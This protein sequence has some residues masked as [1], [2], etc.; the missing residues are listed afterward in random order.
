MGNRW[1]HVENNSFPSLSITTSHYSCKC[2]VA[3]SRLF[4]HACVCVHACPWSI[5]AEAGGGKCVSWHFHSVMCVLTNVIAFATLTVQYNKYYHQFAPNLLLQFCLSFCL[6]H[7]MSIRECIQFWKT[8]LGGD[9]FQRQ[10]PDS[11]CLFVSC[12]A[13][14]CLQLKIG[15]IRFLK[16]LSGVICVIHSGKCARLK[17]VN[18]HLVLKF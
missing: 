7:G 4:K 5:Y 9:L 11:S 3:M 14:F 12:R 17:T 2:K 16:Y 13:V 1:A 8:I 15:F 10:F 6:M 18:N